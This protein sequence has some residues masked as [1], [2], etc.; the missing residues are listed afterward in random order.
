M[1]GSGDRVGMHAI[2]IDDT[3]EFTVLAC[4]GAR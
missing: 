3:Q 1:I 4:W 2:A